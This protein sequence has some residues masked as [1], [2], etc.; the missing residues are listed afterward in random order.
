MRGACSMRVDT[1]SIILSAIALISGCTLAVEMA[2]SEILGNVVAQ[3]KARAAREE[4]ANRPP[5]A[6]Y[7]ISDTNRAFGSFVGGKAAVSSLGA[8][9]TE[10]SDCRAF[11]PI[12]IEYQITIPQFI[13]K[14]LYDELRA[15]GLYDGI[16]GAQW[17]GEITKIALIINSSL[18]SG[19]WDLGVRIRSD[20]GAEV[21]LESRHAFEVRNDLQWACERAAPAALGAATHSLLKDLA[22][23]PKFESLLR[24]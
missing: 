16:R 18:A 6:R 19:W 15:A 20:T 8:P 17:S 21:S 12:P 7:Q 14:A 2:G 5:P 22:S 24:F 11:G 1:I 23:N 9:A 3:D 4:A 13:A 10:R